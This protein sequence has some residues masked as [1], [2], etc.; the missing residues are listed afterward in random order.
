MHDASL[1]VFTGIGLLLVLLP[2]P[3]QWRA[4]NSG[5]LLLITWLFIGNL[6]IFVNC[7]AWWDS[8]SNPSPV[9]CDIV[10]KILIG[11]PVGISAS[12]LCITRR[13]VMIASSSTVAISQS[14]K[15]KALLLD[16]SL[17]AILP[18][19]VMALHY[20]VQPHR[21]DIFEGYGCQVSTRP[22]VA[23][24]FAVTL[25]SPVITI[26]AAVYGIIAIK[27]FL[28]RRLQF[29]TILKSSRSGL[30]NRHY[31]R[32]LALASVDIIIGL[33]LTLFSLAKTI[34]QR[35]SYPSWAWVHANW[36]RVDIYQ[37]DM[38]MT[39]ES[40]IVNLSLPRWF[41][42]LLTMI[43][44][45]FFGVSTEAIAEY[46]RWLRWLRQQSGLNFASR[47]EELPTVI[48][49]LGS[50]IVQPLGSVRNDGATSE[51]ESWK[52]SESLEPPSMERHVIAKPVTVA[53]SVER[54]IA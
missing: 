11:L 42:A 21:F 44:F 35:M 52:D 50:T 26:V 41:P 36:S 29:Q 47:K 34:Q 46:C 6:V 51:E 25:W 14:K 27:L 24:V 8:Y 16:L 3:L 19:V 31:I 7:I 10:S 54:E 48:P 9:W 45:L 15:R 20:T 2:L 12:S 33:P 28:S 1:I 13:L 30:D 39:S 4:R 18:M 40:A 37:A 5:T 49:K 17:G 43:F 38:Y 32:L 23:S 22:S 53:V